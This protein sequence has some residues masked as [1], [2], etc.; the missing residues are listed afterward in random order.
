MLILAHRAHI[1][2]NAQ[3]CKLFLSSS[4]FII[5]FSLT[6]STP[7]TL[8]EKLVTRRRWS[9]IAVLDALNNGA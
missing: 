5:A 6:L 4:S 8:A 1:R 7:R 2:F 9:F 3:L